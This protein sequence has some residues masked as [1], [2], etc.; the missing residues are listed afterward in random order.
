MQEYCIWHATA[1]GGFMLHVEAYS[2]S[3]KSEDFWIPKA[4]WSQNKWPH[5]RDR[6]LVVLQFTIVRNK[7]EAESWELSGLRSIGLG[8][9]LQTNV[10]GLGIERSFRRLMLGGDP[11]LQPVLT[12]LGKKLCWDMGLYGST[13]WQNG[14]GALLWQGSQQHTLR[15]LLPSSVGSRDGLE[16]P[17]EDTGL[18]QQQLDQLSTIGRC[19]YEKTCALLVQLFDQSA[20][21]YQELLQS[22][23]ASPMDIAVQEGK[24]APTCRQHPFTHCHLPFTSPLQKTFRPQS[25]SYKREYLIIV[26]WGTREER[27]KSCL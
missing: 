26:P 14:G 23:S 22:A 1:H 2:T 25:A 6:L 13:W 11:C 12:F 18:V 19:E 21:S 24:W 5:S 20:Q 16:D 17:L 8:K 27:L 7:R 4:I 10:T 3:W 9:S 15:G